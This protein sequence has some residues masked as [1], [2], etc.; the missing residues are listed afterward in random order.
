MGFDVNGLIESV[1]VDGQRVALSQNLMWYHAMEKGSSGVYFNDRPSGAYVFRPK[2]TNAM[3]IS[4][5]ASLTVHTGSLIAS[6]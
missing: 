4:E 6:F 2:G 5:A 3:P 1:T